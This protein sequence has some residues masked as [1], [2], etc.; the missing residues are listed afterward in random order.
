MEL[1]FSPGSGTDHLKYY[2]FKAD[3]LI[4]SFHYYTYYLW[5]KNPTVLIY[6]YNH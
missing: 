2:F 1:D 4:T 5:L 3:G 6:S